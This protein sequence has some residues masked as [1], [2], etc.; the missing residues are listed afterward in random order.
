MECKIWSGTHFCASQLNKVEDR[1][2][3]WIKAASSFRTMDSCCGSNWDSRSLNCW[4]GFRNFH[5]AG[6]EVECLSNPMFLWRCTLYIL[7][8]SA[9]YNKK[10][11]IVTIWI[12]W[13]NFWDNELFC[14]LL[15]TNMYYSAL[16]MF[17][18]TVSSVPGT[19]SLRNILCPCLPVIIWKTTLVVHMLCTLCRIWWHI[20]TLTF[21]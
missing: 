18:T 11:T 6:L 16:I 21:S 19:G 7:K 2:L 4:I 20:G 8:M 9:V 12:N 14:T 13:S 3:S 10:L 15:N 5:S 17:A 1:C